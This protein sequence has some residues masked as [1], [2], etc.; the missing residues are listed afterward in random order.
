MATPLC[1][2]LG[3]PSR[4][5]DGGVQAAGIVTPMAFTHVIEPALGGQAYGFFLISLG[6][7]FLA[8]GSLFLWLWTGTEEEGRAEREMHCVSAAPVPGWSAQCAAA[9][10]AVGGVPAMPAGQACAAD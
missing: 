1:A 10:R 4:P 5:C 7:L 6:L 3:P 8:T 2:D 9:L